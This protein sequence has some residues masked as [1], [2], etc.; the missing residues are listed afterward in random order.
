MENM[1][2]PDVDTP[3][4]LIDLEIVENNLYQMQQKANQCGVALRP[5]IKTHKITEFALMQL[6]LG[7]IG[8][9]TSKVSE[10]EV[11]ADAGIRDIFIANQIVA[12][13]KIMRLLDLS[14]RLNVSVGLDS[15]EGARRLSEVF[16]NQ[17]CS[18][19]YLIEINSGLNRCGVPP[20][21]PAVEL[22]QAVQQFPGLRYKGVFTHAGQVYG[23]QSRREVEQVGQL[24]SRSVAETAALLQDQ[25]I[26][27]EVVSVGSTPTMKI[28]Q[29][30]IGV[31]EIRP[32][33]YIFHDAIQMALDVAR[34]EE[35]ALTVLATV[36]SRPASERAVIDAGSKVLAL[37]KGG[38]GT[39]MVQGFGRAMGKKA[40]LERLSE[41]HGILAV[42]PAENLAIGERVR[43]LPNHACTVINLSD[44]AYGLRNGKV[45]KEMKIAGRG[46]VH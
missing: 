16:S 29:G 46:K 2:I 5:H 37:D 17:G 20:G 30:Y 28:W 21:Q 45:E 9:T 11:M 26:P 4:I 44:R 3:A 41:E 40:V 27:S 38:H 7:A 1:N 31:N 22:L 42:N 15:V 32:G 43:I 14:R 10:S 33:N 6:K 19:D 24:E 34:P 12:P 39:E 35:C 25:S 23:K 36:I 13:K 8:I 18:I